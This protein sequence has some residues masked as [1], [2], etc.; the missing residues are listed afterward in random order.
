M[1]AFSYLLAICLSIIDKYADK[2]DGKSGSDLCEEDKFK[3]RDLLKFGAKFWL[4]AV[5]CI[6]IY[7][8]V[9]PYM[10]FVT[11]MLQ[12]KYCIPDNKDNEAGKLFGIPYII[13]GISSPFLGFL[14]DKV[15]R[16]VIFILMSSVFL[17]AAH[18]MTMFLPTAVQPC[19][20]ATVSYAEIGPLILLGVGFSIYAAALWPCIPYVVEAKTLGTAF[21]ICT[22]L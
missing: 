22:A 9:F 16:R 1:C 18:L 13:S 8:A 21:G 15:G 6:L 19:S 11:K 2:V 14:I 20:E 5:S 12:T 7:A 17:L 10:Q 3:W 4:I